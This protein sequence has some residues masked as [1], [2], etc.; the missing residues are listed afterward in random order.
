MQRLDAL[1][2]GLWTAGLFCRLSLFLYLF[3]LC[4]GKAFG[5]R[6]SRFAIIVGGTA[7][8]I[9]GTVTADMGFTS[10]IFNINFWLWFTLVSAVFIPTFLLICY[11]V[12]TSGKKNKTHKKSG[13]K[14]LILTI[15]I[16]LT[17]LTFSGCMSRAELNEKSHSRG[18]RHR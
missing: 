16:G 5:K 9:F 6:T 14:S 3:A 10:F 15:G 12:K 7:I 11:V 17:V 2:I 13:A 8:L 18:Y 1:F 4:V